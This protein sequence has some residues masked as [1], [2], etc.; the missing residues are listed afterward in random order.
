MIGSCAD[1]RVFSGHHRTQRG[2]SSADR[3]RERKEAEAALIESEARYRLLAENATDI[4]WTTDMNFQ[5]TYVSLA[6]EQILGYSVEEGLTLNLENILTPT[7]C[8]AAKR[9]FL[10]ELVTE[11]RNGEDSP[12]TRTLEVEAIR[13]DGDKVWLEIKLRF[14]RDVKGRPTGALS[15]ARDI[16]E[17]KSLQAQFHQ[18]QKMEAVGRLAGGVA[19]DF[20]NLMTAVLGY[21]GLAL[22]QLD[23]GDLVRQDVLEIKKAGER[24]AALTRQLLIFSR[25]E[26]LETQ[27]VNLNY[28]VVNLKKMLRRL[29]GEHIELAAVLAENLGTIE[30]N[31][32]QIEQ[33]II[34]L[35]INARD[36]MPKGGEITIETANVVL[37][38]DYARQ[39]LDVTPGPY[40]MLA[41][42]DTGHGMD[43]ETQGRVFDPFFTTK[44]QGQGTGL[45][46]ATVHGIVKQNNGHIWL[47]SEPGYGTSFKIYL[48]QVEDEAAP[49][50]AAETATQPSSGDETILLVE[51]EKMVRELAQ[52]VLTRAGYTTLP[53]QH[54]PEALQI[55]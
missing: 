48:P 33:I 2:G 51:D 4:I 5:T 22:H 32:G 13:K 41:V 28:I 55:N 11:K 19:H 21:C 17:R 20:N 12:R 39:H 53:A 47:Y 30:S 24:A 38:R 6:I 9:V 44:E 46:L 45:G 42:S 15:V 7:S 29:I 3:K 50:R 14:L 40:V 23:E 43:R 54:G 36:A 26:A 18:A 52:H 34:N 27:I 1:D 16:S 35:A 31:S 8:Q 37:D 25:Q 10:T 49:T